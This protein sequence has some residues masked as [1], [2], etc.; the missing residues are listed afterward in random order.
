MLISQFIFRF[1]TLDFFHIYIEYSGKT[2]I[3]RKR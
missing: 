1:F 3:S 2:C